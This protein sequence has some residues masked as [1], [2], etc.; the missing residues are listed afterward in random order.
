MSA[1]APVDVPLPLEPPLAD[2]AGTAPV[3][4]PGAGGPDA[5]RR[6]W[7][8][9]ADRPLRSAALSAG[10]WLAARVLGVALP[11]SVVRQRHGH[12]LLAFET[13]RLL[14]LAAAGECVPEV[15]R[16]DAFELHTRDVG[17]TLDHVLVHTPNP[18]D[19]L[20][21][22]C[23]ACADLAG[24]HARGHWHGG[25]Q[26]RNMTWDGQQFFRIDFEEPLRP[27]LSLPMVQAYELL[28][29]AISVL[30]WV[31]PMAPDAMGRM[32]ARYAQVAP[33]QAEALRGVLYE[34]LPRLTRLQRVLAW[35]PRWR[36]SREHERLA[37]L[38]DAL[39][40]FMHAAAP[41][42]QD[43]TALTDLEDDPTVAAFLARWHQQRD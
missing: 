11:W 34:L 22:L 25:A 21:L 27:A 30:R 6:V 28:Q 19:Q 16:Y 39:H 17:P 20:A 14:A 32:L 31:V 37:V 5:E 42:D 36:R 26:V 18:D 33:V 3:P 41:S 12:S 7:V 29:F 43:S 13:Q 15:L 38:L 4:Q 23:A 8:K 2:G 9:R 24:F 35:W 10:V 40:R 1:S